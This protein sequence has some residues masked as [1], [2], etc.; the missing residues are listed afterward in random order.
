MSVASEF[1]RHFVGR[2]IVVLF[3]KYVTTL[4]HLKVNLV[5]KDGCFF[6]VHHSDLISI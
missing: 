1:D 4:L 5:L 6:S 3:C 2:D